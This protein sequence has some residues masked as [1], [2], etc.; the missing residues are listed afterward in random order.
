MKFCSHFLLDIQS[1]SAN[2]SGFAQVKKPHAWYW[3]A[4]TGQNLGSQKFGFTDSDPVIANQYYACGFFACG[5]GWT[6]ATLEQFADLVR[7]SS[8]KCEQIFS[9]MRWKWYEYYFATFRKY[10]FILASGAMRQK[11]FACGEPNRCTDVINSGF[12]SNMAEMDMV[13]TAM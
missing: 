3:F 10:I 7:T 13:Q 11:P 9:T 6:C 8:K 5:T 4:I 12:V 2:C 1:K